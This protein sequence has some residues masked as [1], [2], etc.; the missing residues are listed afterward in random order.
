MAASS[1]VSGARSRPHQ[2]VNHEWILTSV[3]DD[4]QRNLAPPSAAVSMRASQRA[5]SGI[6]SSQLCRTSRRA[7]HIRPATQFAFPLSDIRARN[8]PDNSTTRR[9]AQ[10]RPPLDCESGG[11]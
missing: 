9:K 2:R 8:S 7:R 5:P 4:D 1:P 11:C 10:P 6:D 3:I